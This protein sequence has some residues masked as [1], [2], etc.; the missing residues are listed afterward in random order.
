MNT[1]IGDG[2]KV[3]FDVFSFQ[4]C[5]K[6]ISIFL[7][8]LVTLTHYT[9]TAPSKGV[10]GLKVVPITTSSVEVHWNMI[11]EV[12]WSGDHETGGY[13]VVYQP[14]SDFPTPLETTPKQDILGIKVRF[15][16]LENVVYHL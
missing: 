10:T 13:R 7:N 12:H 15:V 6:Y 16:C 14:V 1:F 2:T 3:F 5:V 8:E 11:N 4:I 9:F